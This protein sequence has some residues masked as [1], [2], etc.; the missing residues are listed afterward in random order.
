[1]TAYDFWLQ[2]GPG[3]PDEE[4]PEPT[5]TEQAQAAFYALPIEQRARARRLAKRSTD[6]RQAN[7]EWRRRQRREDINGQVI[8]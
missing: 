7:R 2:Q 1:M 3:G 6:R 8:F 5:P 4:E